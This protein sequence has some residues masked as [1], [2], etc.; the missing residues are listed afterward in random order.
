[1]RIAGSLVTQAMERPI[2]ATATIAEHALRVPGADEHSWRAIVMGEASWAVVRRG[3]LKSAQALVERALD[4]QRS[5]ARFSASVWSYA[6][7]HYSAFEDQDWALPLATEAL[8]RAEAAGDVPG[9]I[10]LRATRALRLTFEQSPQARL[11]AERALTDARA[12]GQP[13]LI[14]MGLYALGSAAFLEDDHEYGLSLLRESVNLSSEIGSSWQTIAGVASLA[15]AEANYGDRARAAELMRSVLVSAYESS[16]TYFVSGAAHVSLT[17]FSRYDR[18]DLV[19]RFDGA[20]GA[21]HQGRAIG[22]GNW[23]LWYQNAVEEART[24]LG[25]ERYE[26]LRAEGALIPPERVIPDIIGEL[27][28]LDLDHPS[29]L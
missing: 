13:A 22:Y 24:T 18:Y 2:W 27:E 8:E 12:T 28:A 15:A 9:S 11:Q 4:A 25:D 1:M 23:R 29:L 17:V 10:A 14:A 21:L 3:D 19:P 26:Q 5:G 16:D 6:M 20:L 7:L